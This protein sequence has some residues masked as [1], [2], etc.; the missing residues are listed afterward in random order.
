[1]LPSLLPG[2]ALFVLAAVLSTALSAV[3]AQA[4]S[5]AETERRLSGL[6]GQI[7]GV[8]Q[9]VQRARG[10][11][12]SAVEALDALSTEIVLREELLGGYRAQ[13]DS[14]QR[15]TGT[16]R[17]SIG[18]LETEI[19]LAK[20][21]Y[22]DRARH[23][24]MYGRR[25]ALALILSAGSVNQMLVR[26]RYL[27]QF[28]G[29]R[30]AQVERIGEQTFELRT[31][32]AD[33]RRSLESTQRLLSQSQ[34]E[35]QTLALRRRERSALV[36]SVRS[37]RSDLEQE[38]AQ[39]RADA[40]DL[41]GLVQ[42]LV[43]QD[44]RRAVAERERAVAAEARRQAAAAEAARVAQAAAAAQARA[45]QARVAGLQRQADDAARRAAARRDLRLRPTPRRQGG[46][47]GAFPTPVPAS[48]PV[49]AARP[50]RPERR[51]PV[52]TAPARPAPRAEPAPA[53]TPRV[54]PRADPVVAA[55]RPASRPAS[56]PRQ[57]PAPATEA[58]GD[59]SASFRA[60]RGR[61]PWPADGTVTGAFGTRTDPTYGTSIQ[62]IGIDI[63]TSPGAPAR[64]VFDGTVERV[65]TMA[66]YGTFVMVSHGGFT[67]IYG[68]LSQVVVARGQTVRAG[69][70]V[71]RAGTAGER[72]GSQ[73]FFALFQD[74]RPADPLGWLRG[75]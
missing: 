8:E 71:G 44:R 31:R 39:R 32:E 18:R 67:T 56:P 15:E 75:R 60:T 12:A 4:Q 46:D 74:G 24:Y 9:Q 54:E 23:A 52:R 64:A 65:G 49:A 10:E 40:R 28:A 2:R 69:Q 17:A 43:A 68:N 63:S 42:T 59:L 53:P 33:V 38:L 21:S 36:A 48:P 22:R 41:E 73:L 45:E 14:T 47:T 16:L 20:S 34:A 27:Q 7:T 50:P 30:K 58:T 57:A 6:R 61:L 3:P 37:R 35:Q 51:A 1:M 66:T 55:P 29:R 11:E 5:R 13:I 19:D 70:T 62:S 72:R 26:A 25:N